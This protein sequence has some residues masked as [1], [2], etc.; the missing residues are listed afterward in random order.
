M[1]GASCASATPAAAAQ[2]A[3]SS[4]GTA[5]VGYD[6]EPLAA[7]NP[8]QGENARRREE[9]R[10]RSH[11]HRAG[12]RQRRV[13]HR[14]GDDRRLRRVDAHA[15]E[16]TSRLQHD[17]GLGAR[18]RAQRRHERARIADAFDVEQDAVGAGSWT[19]A[20]SNSPKPTSMPPPSETTVEKPICIGP[21]KSSIAVHTAPDCATSASR[22]GSAVGAQN[23]A[24]SPMSVRTTPNAPGPSNRMPRFL[25]IAATV[26]PPR[27]AD[28]G[29]GGVR[30][31]H[32]RRRA[33]LGPRIVENRRDGAGAASR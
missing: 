5:A 30:K 23:V 31:R 16:R 33:H 6:G 4:A 13:E 3:A 10:V 9:L 2:S 17:D 19:S 24:L 26:A 14:V 29:I 18:G 25:A 15:L 21:A 20:S 28:R 22:P 1:A 8:A 32:Q 12:A 27:A 7:R 11:A